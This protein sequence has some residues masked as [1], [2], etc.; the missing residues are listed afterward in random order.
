MEMKLKP[1]TEP[2]SALHKDLRTAL[3]SYN[4]KLT[5]LEMLGVLSH[6]VGVMVTFQDNMT[7]EQAMTVVEYNINKGNQDAVDAV[8]SGFAQMMEAPKSTDSIN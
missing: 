5:P 8:D 6:L 2:Q 1:P 4:D 3:Y 7:T